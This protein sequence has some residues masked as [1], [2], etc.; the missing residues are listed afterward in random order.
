MTDFTV[1]GSTGFIGRHLVEALRQNGHNV[2]AI[3][4]NIDFSAKQH[5]GYVIYAA[6]AT[7][8]SA[9]SQAAMLD[10]HASLPEKIINH[11]DFNS[12]VY[13]SST[14]VYGLEADALSTDE[15]SRLSC[16]PTASDWF[17]LT[18]LCGESLCLN[19]KKPG[20]S[21]ARLANIY[22]KD[23][24]PS[25]FLS[26][27]RRDCIERGG[28]TINEA[29]QSC[30]DYLSIHDTVRYLSSLATSG[31]EGIYNVASGSNITHASI[32]ATLETLGFQVNFN[33][34]GSERRFARINT[35]SITQLFGAPAHSLLQDLPAL[36][37]KNAH[38]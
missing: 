3:G 26:A 7:G 18:K 15:N 6:G 29:P 34:E 2:R 33:P 25:T 4:R 11:F 36:F 38:A 16:S 22:G 17:A 5:L 24:H 32:A 28:A 10:V 14:R 21:V 1:F 37:G 31:V 35:D 23:Q 8:G 9:I 27:I 13:L 12:F 19:A 20:V 30:K